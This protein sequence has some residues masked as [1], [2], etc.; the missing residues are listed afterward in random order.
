MHS[1]REHPAERRGFAA[2]T[3]DRILDPRVLAGFGLVLSAH[4]G[5]DLDEQLGA[6]SLFL[7][8]QYVSGPIERSR[9]LVNAV[10]FGHHIIGFSLSNHKAELYQSASTGFCPA[11]GD[12]LSLMIMTFCAGAMM[13]DELTFA[14]RDSF[15]EWLSENHQASRGIWLVLG[16]AGKLKTLSANEALENALCFGSTDSCGALT[17]S[18]T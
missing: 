17:K 16:K 6:G 18:G 8:Q 9:R 15:R 12:K 7:F 1:Q 3:V 2:E 4:S 14:D 11:H 13:R 5:N 10:E